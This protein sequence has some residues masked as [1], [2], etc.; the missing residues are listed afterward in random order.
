[1]LIAK[2]F[3]PDGFFVSLHEPLGCDELTSCR[4]NFLPDHSGLRRPRLALI[5]IQLLRKGAVTA[6]CFSLVVTDLVLQTSVNLNV[7]DTQGCMRG[8][9]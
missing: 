5:S 1:M 3:L 2:G 4:C 6:T 7:S 9:A 8:L